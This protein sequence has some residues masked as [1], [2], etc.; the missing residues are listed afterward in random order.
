LVEGIQPDRTHPDFRLWLTSM[1]DKAFP[2]SILQ[3]AIKMTNE[4]PKGVRANL[5]GSFSAVNEAWFEDCA[6]PVAFKN[7]LFGLCFFHAVVQE[8]RRFGPLGWNEVYTFT[9]ADLSIS[10]SQLRMFL[11]D[12]APAEA[13]EALVEY[14]NMRTAAK[15]GSAALAASAAPAAQASSSLSSAR[16]PSSRRMSQASARSAASVEVKEEED[17]NLN[18][19]EGIAPV[20]PFPALQ[21]LV[22]ACNYGGRVTDDKDARV[23]SAL[24]RAH[25]GEQVLEPGCPLSESGTYAVPLPGPL[26]SYMDYV[27]SLPLMVCCDRAVH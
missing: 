23:L 17:E 11:D 25:Y 24:L 18:P 5:I 26:S 6:Q 4:P 1:P 21:Y 8:R 22:A 27:R 3:R 12:C 15:G 10:V 16:M 19:F 2:I 14:R 7:L 20:V 9:D 13:H